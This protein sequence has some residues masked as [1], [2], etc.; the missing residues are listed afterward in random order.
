[1]V[2]RSMLAS[3]SGEMDRARFLLILGVSLGLEKRDTEDNTGGGGGTHDLNEHQNSAGEPNHCS[4]EQNT[5]PKDH[6]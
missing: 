5:S 3:D 1:M 2:W 4:R 6:Q